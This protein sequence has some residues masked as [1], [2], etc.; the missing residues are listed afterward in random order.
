[1]IKDK[2]EEIELPKISIGDILWSVQKG[3]SMEGAL[4]EI[5][6]QINEIVTEIEFHLKEFEQVIEKLTDEVDEKCA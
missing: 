5:A 2:I 3:Y 1:M 4:E 6:I